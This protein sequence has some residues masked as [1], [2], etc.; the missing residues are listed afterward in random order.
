MKIEEPERQH[1]ES[2]KNLI[3]NIEAGLTL[4]PEFQRDFVWELYKTYELF[5]SLVKDIFVGAIIYGKPSFEIA[6]REI[7]TYEG[8]NKRRKRK[9]VIKLTRE[10]IAKRNL[11]GHLRIILDGQ[12][13]S[14]SLYRALKGI[15]EVWFIAKNESDYLKGSIEEQKI[16]EKPFN[17]RTLE[18]ILYCFTGE[19]D[20][21]RLSIK[22]SDAYT[23]KQEGLRESKY[24][25][26]YFDKQAYKGENDYENEKMFD[27]YFS[28][29]EKFDDLFKREKLLSYYLLDMSM[30]KFTLFFERSNS[31][32]V[33]L[34]FTDILA[35]KLYAGDFNLRDEI[36]KFEDKYPQYKDYFN[37]ELITRTIAYIIGDGKE[38][39]DKGYI[40]Q[41]LTATHFKDYW[42]QVC[43][44]YVQTLNFLA[45]NHFIIAQS[46][47]PYETMLL[48]L[49]IFRKELNRD[50][51]Q[52]TQEQSKFLQYWYWSS[53]FSQRY[54]GATNEIIIKDAHSLRLVARKEKI[55]DK[56]FF[57]MLSKCLITK[58][59]HLYD[60]TRKAN[61]IYQGVLNLLNFHSKGL[62]GWENTN[63]LNFNDNRLEDHH[64]IPYSFIKKKTNGDMEAMQ[65]V[66]SV[67]NRTLIPKLSNIKISDS[68]P[69]K[70]F[71]V[72]LS[73]NTD[74]PLSLEN[75]QIPIEILN[76]EFDDYYSVILE[77]RAEMLFQVIKLHILKKTDEILQLWYKESE[78]GKGGNLKI[79]ADYYNRTFHATFDIE[80]R[81]IMYNG[82]TYTSPSAAAEAVKLEVT[83]KEVSANGWDFWKYEDENGEEQ[84]LKRL[85]DKD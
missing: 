84:L 81:N 6:V 13:R 33:S 15:D 67:V 38:K 52:M 34:N 25:T 51:S 63:K 1:S 27:D 78:V 55:M 45:D 31:R 19:E 57:S 73:K 22:M 3:A 59:E 83:G 72:L 32:G 30:E 8:R 79:F 21:T 62:I 7:D 17:K 60:Y 61:A 54:S 71:A 69:S 11:H 36:V 64:I 85:R 23:I 4:L 28:L 50:F 46:W 16:G 43:E 66:D 2:I 40:L 37:K 5:D 80:N 49:I 14:T 76:S 70:Y 82:K 42:E 12:Q 75:H 20:K 10:E 56:S 44:W 53:I 26:I 9:E 77:Q 58:R 47:M 39:I 24:K 74:L 68:P 18:E 29:V 35:A 41:N 65:L 48:P